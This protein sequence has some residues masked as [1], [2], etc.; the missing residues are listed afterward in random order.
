MTDFNILTRPHSRSFTG[1]LLFCS[2]AFFV[3]LAASPATAQNTQETEEKPKQ[4]EVKQAEK[5]EKAGE[6]EEKASEKKDPEKKPQ[7]VKRLLP[8]LVK[9][10]APMQQGPGIGKPL[11]IL[12]KPFIK[13]DSVKIPVK[14]PEKTE[15]TKAE[16]NQDTKADQDPLQQPQDEGQPLG[17][18]QSGPDLQSG[19][20]TA[21]DPSGLALLPIGA[22]TAPKD[23]WQGYDRAEIIKNLRFFN[24][25]SQS[26]SL[27]AVGQMMVKSAID[28]PAPTAAM[29][30][31]S[32]YASNTDVLTFIKARL[33]IM[34]SKGDLAGLKMMLSRLPGGQD[35]SAFDKT[36][37]RVALAQDK[38]SE[39]CAL[40]GT[41]VSQASASRDPYWL[42]LLTFCS[43]IDGNRDSV[44]FQ[45]SLL[46]EM[47]ALSP[48][49]YKLVDHILIEAE[50][51]SQASFT[52]QIDQPAKVAL[53]E[54]TMITVARAQ[55]DQLDTS[56]VDPMAVPVMLA[57][58]GVSQT[59]K[60]ELLQKAMPTGALKSTV[61]ADALI[62]LLLRLDVD[63]ATS[64]AAD[65][66]IAKEL[67][68]LAPK[69]PKAAEIEAQESGD[70]QVAIISPFTAR[71]ILA[72]R[73]LPDTGAALSAA[74]I[75]ALDNLWQ[76][77]VADGTLNQWLDYFTA[78]VGS[79]APALENAD[80]AAMAM[81][82]HYLRGA[83]DQAQAWFILLRL[84]QVGKN[85]ALDQVL[86]N[87]Y[88]LALAAQPKAGSFDDHAASLWWDNIKTQPQAYYHGSLVASLLEASG[89]T[90]SED[91]WT[92]LAK[93]PA[94]LERKAIAPALWRQ[95]LQQARSGDRR[96]LLSGGVQLVNSV[97]LNAMPATLAGSVTGHLKDAGYDQLAARVSTEMMILSGL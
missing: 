59:A 53:L 66:I 15:Q 32:G 12:P 3:L 39:A 60:I 88:P 8:P 31:A 73:G 46:D 34:A 22:E 2:V 4:E 74:N 69:A 19:A 9:S 94:S 1:G 90:V 86:I 95:M 81:R 35:W 92:K 43:A 6:L 97:G 5:T 79:V 83:A 89:A 72:K 28:L 71:L 30:D 64:A 70:Q 49:F 11:S 55:A 41:K 25:H 96:A 17:D 65:Q 45:V 42:R 63:A 23:F 58:P 62:N 84:Q 51:G 29:N 76:L 82:T 85:P 21:L 38:R 61:A 91:L 40:A 20:L 18:N 67:A 7:K 27:N 14:T 87:A 26:E 37:S 57:A 16:Q 48:A 24:Q 93:G 10:P 52:P 36:R 68:V 47:G 80:V 33:D 50:T 13:K 77:A 75:Q 56:T 78:T 54:A 44:D